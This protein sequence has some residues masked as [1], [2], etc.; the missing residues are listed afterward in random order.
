[1]GELDPAAFEVGETVI[2]IAAVEIGPAGHPTGLEHQF[3]RRR[4]EKEDLLPGGNDPATQQP[5]E[6]LSEPR[7][8]GEDE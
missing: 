4:R 3:P 1:M 6:K 8:A 2:D 7:A 5:R